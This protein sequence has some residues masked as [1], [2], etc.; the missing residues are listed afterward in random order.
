MGF[1]FNGITSKSM[2]IPSRMTV[3]NRIPSLRNST[4]E[5]AGKHGV[6][7]F[8]SKFSEREIDIE[9]LIPYCKTQ[10]EL[11]ALKDKLAGWLN[12]EAG[13]CELRLETEPDRVYY[14]RLRDGVSF[15]RIT[16][17]SA[18]F[19]IPFFC[20]DPY[21]YAAEDEVFTLT[22][23]GTVTRTLGNVES[24]PVY[25]VCG[26]LANT[27]RTLT[28]SVDGVD[29]TVKG[30]LADG[31]VLYIDTDNMTAWIQSA[32]GTVRNALGSIT[33]LNFPY[34]P[35]GD[36]VITMSASGGTFTSLTV[37]A[38]SCWL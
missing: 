14:A 31:E 15:E 36:A 11:L 8:G 13:V 34:L 6:V 20:P 1:T 4:A 5:I 10:A 22:E 3:E 35:V 17:Q 37:N 12:P 19:E 25:E 29:V 9:C 2:G 32:A 26:V 23:D 16:R 38:K 30:P 33:E 18:S 27:N 24:H 7:D 21:A 28:F